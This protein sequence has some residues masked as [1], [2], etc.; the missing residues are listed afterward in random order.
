MN[1]LATQKKGFPKPDDFYLQTCKDKCK[2]LITDDIREGI[3]SCT[4]GRDGS[5]GVLRKIGLMNEGN[6]CYINCIVQAL[7]MCK[8]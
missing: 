8:Q 2:A 3:I 5:I 7:Y 6:T 1:S 4:S